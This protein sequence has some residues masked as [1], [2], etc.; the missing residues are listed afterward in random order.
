MTDD[1]IT[2]TASIIVS[3]EE[4]RKMRQQDLQRWKRRA[5]RKIAAQ[6]YMTIPDRPL[7]ERAHL[8]AWNDAC[9]VA[10]K[11]INAKWKNI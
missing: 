7:E 10:L 5:T 3:G 1:R 6:K 11:I 9:D 4:V 2:N 8:Q